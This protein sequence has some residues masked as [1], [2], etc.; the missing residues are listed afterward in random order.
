M[1]LALVV[2][3]SVLLVACTA[4]T[5]SRPN[6]YNYPPSYLQSFP[7]NI[8]ESDA[9][10]KLGPPDQIIESNGRKMLVYKPNLKASMSYSVI[11][12]NDMVDDI[13]YN[14]SGSLNGSSAKALQSGKDVAK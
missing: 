10:A 13:I 14:E 2:I 3:A 7:L 5:G 9:V 4:T 1:K 6:R 8:S 11:I 12:I